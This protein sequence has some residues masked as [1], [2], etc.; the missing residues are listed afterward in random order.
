MMVRSMAK[1]ETK[2]IQEVNTR[3]VS[4]DGGD[5][6][7]GHPKVYLTIG[8]SNEIECPYCGKTFVLKGDGHRGDH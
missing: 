6:D 2:S 7:L 3:T 5:E 4:C 1:N 8:R